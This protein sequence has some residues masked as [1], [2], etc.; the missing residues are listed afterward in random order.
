MAHCEHIRIYRDYT[1][2]VSGTHAEAN[3]NV[4]QKHLSTELE[5]A[6]AE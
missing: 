5:T 6:E 3:P 1:M 4:A 2:R